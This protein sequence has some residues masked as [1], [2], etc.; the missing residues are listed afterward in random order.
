MLRAARLLARLEFNLEERTAEL[1]QNALDLLDRVSGERILNELELIFRERLPERALQQLDR[2]GILE[3]IHSGL[4]VDDWLIERLQVL[5][6]GLQQTPWANVSPDTI[7]YLGLIAFYLAGDELEALV[8]RL[9]L[10]TDQRTLL[11]QVYTIRRNSTKIA[12]AKKNSTLYHLLAPTSDEARL[13]AW[14]GLDEETARGQIIHYQTTLRDMAPIIDGHY[15]KEAFQ[16]PPGPIYRQILDR[17]RDAQL[18]GLVTT[19]ADER[20]LVEQML[21]NE[22]AEAEEPQE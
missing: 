8:E 1:L 19:L 16:L 3:V 6:S 21:A 20:A 14:L 9:N 22:P 2:L 18:D 4:V 13:I 15:L 12:D 17:L 10:R 7:H 11:K 5:R